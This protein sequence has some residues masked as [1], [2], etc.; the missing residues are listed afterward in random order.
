MS[1]SYHPPVVFLCD[2]DG[3]YEPFVRYGLPND[4]SPALNDIIRN[5]SLGVDRSP[6]SIDDTTFASMSDTFTMSTFAPFGMARPPMG[7]MSLMYLYA[8]CMVGMSDL[9]YLSRSSRSMMLCSLLTA[10]RG[11]AD[12]PAS[13]NSRCIAYFR[14]VCNITVCSAVYVTVLLVS[15]DVSV[16][17]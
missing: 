13:L 7:Y 3:V 12:L 14:M 9:S 4:V 8:L 1:V 17:A 10:S 6:M 11:L 2:A 5:Q 16:L 15:T